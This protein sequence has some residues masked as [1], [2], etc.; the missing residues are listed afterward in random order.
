MNIDDMFALLTTGPSWAGVI[1]G[2]ILVLAILFIGV[3]AF[4]RNK[5]ELGT[6]GFM[7]LIFIGI[8]LSTLVGLFPAYVILVFLIGSVA[9][10]VIKQ[11]FFKGDK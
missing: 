3:T 11:L 5:V 2:F 8:L 10:I 7:I 9:V 4:G 6:Y 1:L